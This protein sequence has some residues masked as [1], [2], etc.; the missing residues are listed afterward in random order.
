MFRNFYHG[1]RPALIGM[2]F[3]A[4]ISFGTFESLKESAME[5]DERFYGFEIKD[6]NGQLHTTVNF[7]L[8]NG[9]SYFHDYRLSP[10]DYG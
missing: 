7:A 8:G 6:E 5:K 10:R 9:L 4:G 2:P 3:Y 1:V